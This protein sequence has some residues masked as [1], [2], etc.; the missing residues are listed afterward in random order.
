MS[1][2]VLAFLKG[3]QVALEEDGEQVW[4]SDADDDFLE[5]FGDAFLDPDDAEEIIEYLVDSGEIEE[6]EAEEMEIESDSLTPEQA[7]VIRA[8][9]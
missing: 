2:L 5:E 1:V 8:D 4:S 9:S 3:G 7:T 6:E